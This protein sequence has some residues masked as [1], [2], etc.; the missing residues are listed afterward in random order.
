[1]SRCQSNYLQVILNKV[2][3]KSK[4]IKKQQKVY[5]TS[6]RKNKFDLE[7]HDFDL[8]QYLNE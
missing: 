3:R 5:E 6:L 1:M 7:N 4:I 2:D 8:M